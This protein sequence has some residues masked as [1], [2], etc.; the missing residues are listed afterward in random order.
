MSEPAEFSEPTGPAQPAGGP[1]AG[2]GERPG[3]A[4]RRAGWKA[5]R[6]AGRKVP[7]PDRPRSASCWPPSTAGARR[8]GCAGDSTTPCG[9]SSI[10][11]IDW[12]AVG[13]PWQGLPDDLWER[14]RSARIGQRLVGDVVGAMADLLAA[15]ARS[16]AEEVAGAVNV[17]VWD[18]LRYLAARVEVLEA[19]IDPLGLEAAEWPGPEPDPA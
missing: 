10:P 8:A 14:G 5:P 2:G 6:T 11:T 16:A 9:G 12:A 4:R 18:A 1:G 13:H 19:R 3:K 7:A 15:D 17:A